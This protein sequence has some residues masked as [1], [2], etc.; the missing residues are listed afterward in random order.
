MLN[1][2]Y[3]ITSLRNLRVCRL[4]LATDRRDLVK[5]AMEVNLG[6][7]SKWEELTYSDRVITSIVQDLKFILKA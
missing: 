3:N 6:K 1:N 5:G 2:S 7:P 4:L